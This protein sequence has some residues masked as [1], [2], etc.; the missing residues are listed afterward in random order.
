MLDRGVVQRARQQFRRH[1]PKALAG[2]ALAA[3]ECPKDGGIEVECRP[4]HDA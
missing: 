2:D 1:L 4:R 3:L